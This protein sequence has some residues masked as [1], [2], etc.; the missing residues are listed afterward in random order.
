MISRHDMASHFRRF[1]AVLAFVAI[2]APLAIGLVWPDSPAAVLKEGRR[3]AN[4]PALPPNLAGWLALPNALDAY[5]KDHFGLR[6]ALI[7]AHRQL[8]KPMLGIGDASVLVGRDG[9]MFYLGEETVRQSAGLIV[10]DRG[11]ADTVALLAAMN[12]DLAERGV[13]LIVAP[14]PNAATVYQDDLPAWAQNSGR[15]TEYDLYLDGLTR[16]G[17]KAVDLR[18]VLRRAAADGA[19]YYRNDSH[20]APK[21]ALAAYNAIVFEDS[22]PE[23]RLDPARALTPPYLRRGGDL[24]RVLGLQDSAGEE[25]EG[26]SLP[27]GSKALLTSDPYGDYVRSSG[28]P[29]PTIMILGDSFTAALFDVMAV[30]NAGRVVWVHHQHCGFD[31]AAIDRFRPDEVWWMPTERRILCD[32]GVR[33]RGFTG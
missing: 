7:G 20:W 33:P 26:L 25:V 17:V 23:W 27:M 8:T 14:P 2:A 29:G 32:P 30:Q 16:A 18:P 13:R 5:L 10:R 6:Q 11:V 21:G 4:A 3:L 24:A 28:N 15:K 22:H 19:A 12:Q 9:R 1:F 31:W